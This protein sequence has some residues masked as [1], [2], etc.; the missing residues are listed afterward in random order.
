VRFK[1]F[2]SAFLSLREN[3]HTQMGGYSV[4]INRNIYLLKNYRLAGGGN[5][6]PEVG[7]HLVFRNPESKLIV[8]ACYK[9]GLCIALFGCLEVPLCSLDEI[10]LD[11]GAC[12]V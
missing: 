6:Q 1:P 5:V 10:L 11:T 4:P 8:H 7:F 9:L 3:V 2:P 12:R